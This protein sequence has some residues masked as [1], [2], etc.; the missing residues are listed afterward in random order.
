MLGG[1][2][3]RVSGGEFPDLRENTGNS[4]EVRLLGGTEP[5]NRQGIAGEI[6]YTRNRDIVD[7]NRECLL[8]QQ[9]LPSPLS[10]FATNVEIDASMAL[11]QAQVKLERREFSPMHR[12]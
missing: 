7:A 5:Q 2:S 4:T 12:G 1:R 3:E 11:M 9:G 6:P 8:R 10:D